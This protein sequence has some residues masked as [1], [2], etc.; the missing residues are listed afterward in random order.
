MSFKKIIQ[1]FRQK[2]V[3]ESYIEESLEQSKVPVILVLVM[4]W[5]VSAVLLLLSENRQ[6]DL[7]V[8]THG[9][10]SPFSFTA[11][12]DFDYEDSAA[13]EKARNAAGRKALA[14]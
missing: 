8:W 9:Q 11:R 13:T 3:N 5:M 10:R 1:Y 2:L 4:I 6:R 14:A 12:I 7:T